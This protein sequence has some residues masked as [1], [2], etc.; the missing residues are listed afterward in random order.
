M[1]S[2][3]AEFS[4]MKRIFNEKTREHFNEFIVYYISGQN[5]SDF[6]SHV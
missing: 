6:M 2:A 3:A 1:E 5:I 4:Q